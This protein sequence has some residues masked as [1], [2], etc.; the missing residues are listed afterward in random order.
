MNQRR[1]RETC[2]A[3]FPSASIV[4]MF[5]SPSRSLANAM[6]LPSGLKRGCMSKAG[7]LVMRVAGDVAAAADRHRV[8]VAEQVEHDLPAVGADVH[9][10]PRAFGRVE[11][12]LLR[13][14]EIRGDI[15]LLAVGLLLRRAVRAERERDDGKRRPR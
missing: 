12:E 14:S 13:R 15:P 6:R 5:Q 9:V 1:S 7:P 8:D 4:Q 11:R 3:F 2:F 10:H